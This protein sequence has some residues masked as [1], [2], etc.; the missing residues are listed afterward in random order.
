MKLKFLIPILF[1]ATLV[2]CKEKRNL[3]SFEKESYDLLER[4]VPNHKDKFIFQ[5]F[6]DLK[7]NKDVFEISSVDEKILIK[8]NNAVSMSSGLYWYLKNYC[9]A[10]ISL[11]YNQ[12]DL[13]KTLPA[14]TEAIKVETPFEYRYIFNYCTYGYSM[15]WWDWERWEQMID[16]MALQGVNMP[17]AMIGQEAVWKEVYNELGLTDKQ[18]EDFFVGPAHLPWG[19]MGNIDG[20]GGP[21]PQ[22]WISRRSELQKKIL[23]RM[24]SLGMKPVLQGF[25]GHVPETLKELYP[26]SKITQIEPW[27]GIPGTHFLDPTDDLFQ[28]IGKLFIEKQTEMYGTDHLYDADCFIEVDPPSNDPEFLKEVSK[29]VYQSMASADPEATWVIQGWFFFF[30]KDFWQPEQGRAFLE[31]IPKNKAIVLD[32][33]GEKFPTWDKTESFYGQPWIWNVICNEDQ[34]VNISG[35]L[36]VMQENF[37]TAFKAEGKNNLRGI[38]VIPEGIGFNPVIQEFIYERAWDTDIIELEKW[39]GD[40]AL[41]RYNTT[42]P[43]A[44]QTWEK[45]LKTVYGR[46]RTMWSPLITT[47]RLVAIDKSKEDIRHVR[48]KIAITDEDRFAWDFDTYEFSEVAKL[49]LELAPELQDSE[50]FKFDMT[51]VYREYLHMFSHRFIHDISEAYQNKDINAL[52]KAGNNLLK[53]LDDLETV[54]GT[55]ENFLLGKWL[56]DAKSWG[57]TPEEK[58]YFEN[59]ARTIITIWQPWKEGG[60]RDYAGK[61][62]NGLFSGYYKPR[63]EL[64]INTLKESLEKNTVFD[65]RAYD[66]AVREIDYNWTHSNELY[67]TEP[68]G[69]I[70]EVAPG[71]INEYQSYFNKAH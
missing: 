18:L 24:R 10:Q 45:M 9:N 23:K 26:N 21:L 29:S 33:Y 52:N 20:L 37:Q 62:W 12:V 56:E 64:F 43:K 66:S 28:K 8:G 68:T 7:S 44:K 35:D 34:K 13:P 70:F 54:T 32:L 38:G 6:S 63:W 53:L 61:T 25:T 19:W 40:Y 41:R 65:A 58:T 55:N 3:T 36:K 22:S 60:L 59:N 50:T 17:L 67:P 51:H 46:T 27:A 42:S 4:I 71:I 30:K 16:Y 1:I 11:N 15:P 47:P 31:A 49:F 14:L 2:G 48:E 69:N 39:I 57:N 5:E